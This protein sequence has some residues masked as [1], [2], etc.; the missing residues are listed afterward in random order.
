MVGRGLRRGGADGN[1]AWR[2][3]KKNKENVHVCI[4]ERQKVDEIKE[5]DNKESEK[6]ETG[7]STVTG[8]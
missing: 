8:L 5:K 6:E 4:S 3:V 2:H 7:A 1:T